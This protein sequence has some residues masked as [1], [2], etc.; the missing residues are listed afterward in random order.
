MATGDAEAVRDL[1]WPAIAAVL[2]V[3]LAILAAGGQ[4]GPR[5]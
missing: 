2:F 3:L 5:R 4:L 1:M